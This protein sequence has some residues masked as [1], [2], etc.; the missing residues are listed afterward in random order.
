VGIAGYNIARLDRKVIWHG[1][2]C[3][4]VRDSVWYNVLFDLMDEKLKFFWLKS[5]LTASPVEYHL[6]LSELFI[7]HQALTTLWSKLSVRVI[8]KDR[9][10]LSWMWR[11]LGDFSKLNLSRIKNAY[12]LKQIVPFR[13]GDKASWTLF[14]QI[15]VHFMTYR[16]IMILSRFNPLLNRPNRVIN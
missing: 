3:M 11:D 6:S 14:T 9:R 2:V 7:T 1:G 5:A 13:P 15:S 10:S 12:G 8:N 16:L 4:Y